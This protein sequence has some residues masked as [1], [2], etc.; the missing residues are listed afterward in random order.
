MLKNVFVN[1]NSD[2]IEGDYLEFGVAYG[3]SLRAAL[4]GEKNLRLRNSIFFVKP[5]GFTVLIH[6]MAFKV[7]IQMINTLFGLETTSI[8]HMKK[9][10]KGFG[11]RL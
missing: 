6:S 1:L 8:Y 5:G 11:A 10:K 4:E 3:N 9:F 7:M 2:G